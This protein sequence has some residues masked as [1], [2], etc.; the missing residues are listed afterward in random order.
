[1]STDTLSDVLTE[2]K[3]LEPLPQVAMRVLQLSREEDVIPREL[4]AVIQTDAGI[5]A[6]VLKLCNIP[7]QL[8]GEILQVNR[9]GFFGGLVT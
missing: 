7:G 2:I 5:T 8:C 3:S 4:V 6:K 9:P 1:M